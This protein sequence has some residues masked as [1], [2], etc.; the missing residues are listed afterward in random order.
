LFS[1][2]RFNSGESQ[3]DYD[4]TDEQRDKWS[5]MIEKQ[6]HNRGALDLIKVLRPYNVHES[7]QINYHNS[8]QEELKQTDDDFVVTPSST[9]NSSSP[10]S[11]RSAGADGG[12]GKYTPIAVTSPKREG[13]WNHVDTTFFMPT[14]EEEHFA[15]SPV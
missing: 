14:L 15:P 12:G 8:A 10:R 7:Q 4:F 5:E 11:P 2:G 3:N 9:N 1:C 13:S 6:A